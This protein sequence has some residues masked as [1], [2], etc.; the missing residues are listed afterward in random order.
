MLDLTNFLPALAGDEVAGNW[1]VT[2]S[3][4]STNPQFQISN[5]SLYVNI[6]PTPFALPLIA[7]AFGI[8]FAVRRF[9]RA[10]TAA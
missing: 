2:G 4:G 8:A 5:A 9:G 10:K 3:Q 1:F 6:I 7:S